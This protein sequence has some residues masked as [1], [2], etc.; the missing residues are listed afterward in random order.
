MRQER[1][2]KKKSVKET[3]A[4]YGCLRH[5]VCNIHVPRQCS[6]KDVDHAFLLQGDMTRAT[7]PSC[8]FFNAG[9]VDMFLSSIKVLMWRIAQRP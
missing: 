2:Q 7:V 4:Y 6:T 3:G 9:N 8:F 5:R 1:L